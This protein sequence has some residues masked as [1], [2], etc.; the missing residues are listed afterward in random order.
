MD[1]NREYDIGEQYAERL[2]TAAVNEETQ[3]LP[4]VLTPEEAAGKA[5]VLLYLRWMERT[6][7]S[8]TL[9]GSYNHIEAGWMGHT[10]DSRRDDDVRIVSA[11]HTSD[12]RVEI[13]A[14]VWQSCCLIP[15]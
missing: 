1:P 12:G 5:E 10:P 4:I 8:F 14:K 7:L 2:N 9:P 6:D 11:N 13:K 15:I 3:D